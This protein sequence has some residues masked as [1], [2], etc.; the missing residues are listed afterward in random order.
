MPTVMASTVLETAVGQVWTL[1]R[2]FGA[3]SDWH[4]GLPPCEIEDGPAD[5]VGAVR[6]FP[7]FGGHRERLVALDD[8]AHTI[9]VA[10]VTNAGLPVRDY[11]TAIQ[12]SPVGAGE[13]SIVEW[14]AWYDCDAVDDEHVAGAVHNVL[15]P[16]LA[17]LAQRF[18]LGDQ[19]SAA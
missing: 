13:R 17:A 2:D 11:V 14:S 6:V 5:R 12:V 16:G 9:T 1:L 18:R 15:D 10:F 7:A 8:R 19:Q 3:I 4:P